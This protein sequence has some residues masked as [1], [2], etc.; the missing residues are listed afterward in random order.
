[1]KM[2]AVENEL[3]HWGEIIVTTAAGDAYELHLGD[4][5]FDAKS[6]M[7]KL[8]TPEAEYLIDGDAVENIKKHYG[9]KIEGGDA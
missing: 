5:T 4:T 2:E 3:K 6:R 7:I 1:M 9:H 8:T